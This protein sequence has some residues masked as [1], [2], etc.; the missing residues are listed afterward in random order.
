MDDN[1]LK[2]K[3][4]L[5]TG[6]SGFTGRHAVDLLTRLGAKVAAVLRVSSGVVL[7]DQVDIYR[8][9]LEDRH[10]VHQ[11]IQSTKPDYVLHLAGQNSVPSSWSDPLTTI[12]TNMMS[13]LYLLDALREIP[14]CRIV[15]I[16]SRLK[17]TPKA[18]SPPAPPH[19]YSL[20]K[21]VEEIVTLA[22]THLY[23]Q[24]IIYAEPGNLIGPGP[25]TG[26]CALL[27]RHVA[28]AEGGSNPDPFRLSSPEDR[29]DFLDVRDAVSAY[30]LLLQKGVPGVVY[31]VV[32]GKE[33]TLG[34]VAELMLSQA[35]GEVP[36]VW[37]SPTSGPG[38]AS[39]ESHPYH[40]SLSELGWAP[41]IPFAKSIQDILN[42][43]RHKE[44]G[45]AA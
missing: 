15:V 45:G 22:W 27:A 4:V 41:Q 11:L 40:S 9:D 10:S 39:S 25:S 32:S 20:S 29:R 5:V 16:G 34:E 38:G 42:D 44:R 43:A 28:S 36:V 6:A 2:G 24:H 21:Y 30:V 13:P 14:H 3:V 23:R 17:Y 12:Q 33:R 19:P 1:S 8:C 26:I 31:P 35:A 18:G 37:G 7:P